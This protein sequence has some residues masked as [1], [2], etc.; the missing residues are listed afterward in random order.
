MRRTINEIYDLIKQKKENAGKYL[1]RLIEIEK[2]D[3]L[4]PELNR[5]AGQNEALL[6]VI[7]LIETSGVLNNDK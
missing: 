6:D 7:I 5:I 1:T 3:R 2:K 4:D